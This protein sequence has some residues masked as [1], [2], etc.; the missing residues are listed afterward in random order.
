MGSYV[1]DFNEI[2]RTQVAV[3]GGKGAALG[4]LS[5]VEGI[6]VPAGCCVTT[7]AFRRIM[8]ETPALD[9]RLAE[10]ARLEPDDRQAI[11]ALA[12]EIRATIEATAVPED[13]RTAIT[14]ALARLGEQTA[15]AVRSS[16]TAEDLPTAS[17]AGQQD[18]YLNVIGPAAI[19]STCAGAG[20]RCSPSGRSPTACATAFD[21]RKCSMAVVRPADGLPAGVRHVVHGRPHHLQPEG[22]RRSRPAFGLGEALV[23]G[24]VNADVYKVRDG[25]V[26]ARSRRQAI[27][28]RDGR[29]AAPRS[30]IAPNSR[31]AGARRT[32]RR[33]A[34]RG[35]AGGSKR[36]SAAPRTSSGA[37][38]TAA[39]RSSRAARSPPCS[40]SPDRR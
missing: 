21:H 28:I 8:G 16:A 7:D 34:S 39:F 18:T 29:R 27:A 13:V 31:A 30:E 2:D 22:R 3:V 33:C 38:P 9:D 10:L 26:I 37:W 24:L 4:E 23:S 11:R 17:F 12:T 15:Y 14:G 20:A 32:R 5:R 36:T 25:E 40:R 19:L 35:S 6:S 1:L